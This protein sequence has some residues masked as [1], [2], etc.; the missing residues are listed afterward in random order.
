MTKENTNTRVRNLH[1][2]RRYTSCRLSL[3]VDTYRVFVHDICECNLKQII[4]Y[5]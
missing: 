5:N 4:N 2:V 3:V 1:S